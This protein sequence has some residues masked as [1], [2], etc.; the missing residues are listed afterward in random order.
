V[1][2]VD[3]SPVMLTILR[4][5]VAAMEMVTNTDRLMVFIYVAIAVKLH[6]SS[7]T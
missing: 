4:L 2:K 3:I 5:F 7:S 1:I 6:A